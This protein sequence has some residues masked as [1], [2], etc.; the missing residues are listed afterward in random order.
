[1]TGP[2][3]QQ[4][5]DTEAA[6]LRVARLRR[7]PVFVGIINGVTVTAAA[8]GMLTFGLVICPLIVGLATG[9]AHGITP[10]WP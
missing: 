7:A 10:L 9:A 1:M 3:L 6:H 8:L 5:F 2:E 4:A